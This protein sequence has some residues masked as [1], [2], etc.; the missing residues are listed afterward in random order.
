[1]ACNLLQDDPMRET[2]NLPPTGATDE[3]KT[4]FEMTRLRLRIENLEQIVHAL[5][6]NRVPTDLADEWLRVSTNPG[7]PA[8]ND[9]LVQRGKDIAAIMGSLESVP[10]P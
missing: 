5:L 4:A 1:M 3:E 9:P 10:S 2:M 7:L 8:S 6:R